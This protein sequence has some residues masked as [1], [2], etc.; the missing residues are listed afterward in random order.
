MVQVETLRLFVLGVNDKRVYGNVGPACALHR[1][2]QK[3]ASESEAAIGKS[4]GKA[5]QARDRN[6]RIARE[7]FDKVGWQ[8]SK[9][10][11]TCGQRV[12]PGDLPGR[13]LAS[14]KTDR[15]AA[16]HI[17]AG[18]VPEIAVKRIDPTGE[19][20]PIVACRERLDYE[21][22]R[23]RDGAISRA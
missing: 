8:P 22:T 4:D 19:L 23:H 2:P 11:P 21:S 12:E 9:W 13:N 16:A 17:L 15:G 5:S 14:H 3:G 1:V 6:R 7:P 18:L 20:R 10:D